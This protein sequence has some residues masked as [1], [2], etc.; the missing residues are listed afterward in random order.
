MA[1]YKLNHDRV[2]QTTIDQ[3]LKQWGQHTNSRQSQDMEFFILPSCPKLSFSPKM[4]IKRGHLI[5]YSANSEAP[6]MKMCII[7][8]NMKLHSIRYLDF[9]KLL[10]LDNR[11]GFCYCFTGSRPI[12]KWAVMFI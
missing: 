2:L 10:C 5:R 11:V 3:D 6:K 1:H 12:I 8:Q 9:I 4:T 7:F